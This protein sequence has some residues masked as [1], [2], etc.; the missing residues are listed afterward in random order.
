M[1]AGEVAVVGPVLAEPGLWW[2][3]QWNWWEELWHWVVVPGLWQ[4]LG[5]MTTEVL[6]WLPWEERAV[7]WLMWLWEIGEKACSCGACQSAWRGL[8]LE[9]GRWLRT[10]YCWGCLEGV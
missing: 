10:C 6:P 5:E 9:D 3:Q 2:W 8:W 4:L 7:G 1:G